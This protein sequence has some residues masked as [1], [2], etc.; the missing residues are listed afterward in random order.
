MKASCDVVIPNSFII[1]LIIS[2]LV[3]LWDSSCILITVFF[4]NAK[5]SIACCP[6]DPRSTE[7]QKN[8]PRLKIKIFFTSSSALQIY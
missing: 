5:H 2:D 1:Y 6:G 4:F 7:T 3:W 8:G